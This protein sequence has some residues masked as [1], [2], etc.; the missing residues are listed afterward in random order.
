M[1]RFLKNHLQGAWFAL[2][3]LLVL[4]SFYYFWVV[5]QHSC[6]ITKIR[7]NP[8]YIQN[9]IYRLNHRNLSL[10]SITYIRLGQMLFVVV[11]SL[12]LRLILCLSYTVGVPCHP[13]N[14]RGG[15]VHRPVVLWSINLSDVS[16]VHAWFPNSSFVILFCML[17]GV[18]KFHFFGTY[19][20]LFCRICM[21]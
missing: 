18:V 5:W 15:W 1:F 3:K 20:C 19:S 10:I 9:I 7:F 17:S 8:E 6:E 11:C 21:A 2:L 4:I 14:W 12:L 16:V 13:C